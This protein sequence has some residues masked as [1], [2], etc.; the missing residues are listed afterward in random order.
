MVVFVYKICSK[1]N[2]DK[3]LILNI[4]CCVQILFFI[5]DNYMLINRLK[6][7]LQTKLCLEIRESFLI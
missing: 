4:L 6:K 3:K 5:N 1:I 2:S 7:Y